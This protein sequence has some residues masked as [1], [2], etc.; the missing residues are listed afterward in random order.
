M[1]HAAT[2]CSYFAAERRSISDPALAQALPR[3]QTDRD[4]GLVQPTAVFGRVVQG[5]PIPQPSSRFLAEPFHDRFAGVRVQVVQHQMDGIGL[6]IA[7]RDVQ[8][9]VGE[10]GRGTVGRHLG[11]VSPH[12]RLH[13]A[14]H[15]GGTATPVFAIPSRDLSR[16]HRLR[17]ANFLM[18][19]HRFSSTQTTGSRS[20]SGFS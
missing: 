10:R 9:V 19:H 4:L 12:F 13:A 1:I 11:K 17:R 7:N 16:L 5:K 15:I 14:E 8:Q 2:P 3:E 20:L 6:G 18:Q